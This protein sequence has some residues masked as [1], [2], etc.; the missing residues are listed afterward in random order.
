VIRASLRALQ[1]RAAAERA[2]FKRLDEVAD[3]CLLTPD[4]EVSLASVAVGIRAL[5]PELELDDE[6]LAS[7]A[8]ETLLR[9]RARQEAS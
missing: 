3:R 2:L 1:R 4:R 6:A 7:L 9:V 5:C 8:S